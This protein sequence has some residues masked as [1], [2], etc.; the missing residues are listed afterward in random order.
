MTTD[1][2]DPLR[3]ALPVA[4]AC[5]LI[6]ASFGSLAAASGVGAGKAIAMS[7]LVFAGGS[8]FAALGVLASGGSALAAVASGL[9]LNARYA[10]FGAAL[11]ELLPAGP[12]RRLAAAHLLIDESA[13]MALAEPDAAR[14]RRTYWG[15]GVAIF[16]LWNL[17]TAAGVWAGSRMGDPAA[18]GLDAA[19]P[20]AMLAILAPMLRTEQARLAAAAGGAVALVLAMFAPAGVPVMGASFGAV[21][22]LA[23]GGGAAGEAS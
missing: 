22:A 5:G 3:A 11:S 13:A 12:M 14:A 9:L 4:V 20:A 18:F 7:S 19:L 2:H 15:A 21:V 23:A 10:A 6:G 1:R 17:G 16:V 8:Q